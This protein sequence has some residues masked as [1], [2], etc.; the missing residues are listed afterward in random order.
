MDWIHPI[1]DILS[2]GPDTIGHWFKISD[3]DTYPAVKLLI[4][5]RGYIF[6]VAVGP[7]KGSIDML[8]TKVEKIVDT[9][10]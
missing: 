9:G 7:I 4:K 10:G 5:K 3:T 2:H 1:P 8:K 6:S